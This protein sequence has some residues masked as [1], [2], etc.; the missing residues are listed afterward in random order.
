MLFMLFVI[1]YAV[2]IAIT[3]V[4]LIYPQ[5]QLIE[6]HMAPIQLGASIVF[7]LI[8]YILIE[9][10]R[11]N[12]VLKLLPIAVT[13]LAIASNIPLSRDELSDL[14]ANGRG[15]TS[16][17]WRSSEV[18]G[19]VSELPEDITLISNEAE[20]IVFWINRPAHRVPEIY[21]QQ[22][23]ESY[24]RFGEDSLDSVQVKFREN[25]AALILFESAYWQFQQIYEEETEKRLEV[26]TDGLYKYF[27]GSDGAIYFYEEKFRP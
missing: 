16:S 20:A 9:V 6:K 21:K 13:C 17:R 25:G 12:K 11:G 23:V 27:E 10:Y 15:L 24:R 3:N 26:F 14:H 7:L 2:M 4:F 5:G 18:L 8:A 19:K 22:P 1:F